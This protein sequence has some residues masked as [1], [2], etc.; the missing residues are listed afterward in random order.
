MVIDC[1]WVTDRA[2]LQW[3]TSMG[4]NA[5]RYEWEEGTGNPEGMG[6]TFNYTLGTMQ[7]QI[8]PT[9]DCDGNPV[10]PTHVTY[11]ARASVAEGAITIRSI[12]PLGT[13]GMLRPGAA[14][15]GIWQWQGRAIQHKLINA[16]L[17]GGN[18]INDHIAGW[19]ASDIPWVDPSCPPPK[20]YAIP[21]LQQ[22]LFSIPV[23]LS[24]YRLGANG[25]ERHRSNKC[26]V[27]FNFLM[28]AQKRHGGNCNFYTLVTH[29]T[30]G[31]LMMWFS[32]DLPSVI[33]GGA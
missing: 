30:I 33:G 14:Y 12:A 8:P 5:D 15:N 10:I 27:Y 1:S 31:E 29:P 18:P 13:D 25:V 19:L 32:Q 21:S 6:S 7:W 22:L 9:V 24:F 20:Y 4:V 17:Q 23:D 11:D 26:R 16:P 2:N 3:D 28:E